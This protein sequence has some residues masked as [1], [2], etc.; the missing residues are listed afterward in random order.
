MLKTERIL[1]YFFMFLLAAF[2]SSSFLTA[3]ESGTGSLQEP[4]AAVGE[5]D[6]Q[7]EK[8]YLAAAGGVILFNTFLSGWNRYVSKASWAQVTPDDMLHCYENERAWDT[9]WYWTNFVLHP[10]QGGLY[11]M[12]ARSSNLNQFESFCIS[13]LGSTAW[14]YLGELNAPSNN[15]L[16]YTPIGGFAVGE[17]LYRLSLEAG[18]LSRLSGYLLNPMKP[19]AEFV[20]G[21]KQPATAGHIYDLSLK[22]S[23]GSTGTYTS[24]SGSAAPDSARELYPVFVSPEVSVVY[25]DP[26][27]WDSDIPYSQFNLTMSG[28]LGAGSGEDGESAAMYDVT[29]LATGMLFSRSP[30]FGPDRD[31]TVGM[32]F[33]YDFLWHSF[34]ELSALSPG[35]AFKQRIRRNDGRTIEWQIHL[36]AL[37]LGTDDYYYFMHGLIPKTG[38]RRNYSYTTGAESVLSWKHTGRD[39]RILDT[40]LRLYAMYDFPGQ[41]QDAAYPGWEFTGIGTLNYEV[42][43]GEHVHVGLGNCLYLKKGVYYGTA[44]VFQRVYTG[45]VFT[46]LTL[47]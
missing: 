30:D 6:S 27:G 45:T 18:G 41:V 34:M 12:A 10:Y 43:V 24:F 46:R 28:A 17:I 5:T 22:L 29:L 21:E 40:G 15:D 1:P 8:H 16:I 4:D 20:T 9:D 11:Y 33:D 39:G 31:T 23:A 42:P 38:T 35:F 32:V 14:E 2:C 37:L 36:D 25:N 47:K 44:D 19:Y 26:Y 13:V 3:E 7:P